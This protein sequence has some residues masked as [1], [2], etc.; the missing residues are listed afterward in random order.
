MISYASRSFLFATKHSVLPTFRKHSVLPTL[1]HRSFCTKSLNAEK[2]EAIAYGMRIRQIVESFLAPRT[3][4]YF[5]KSIRTSTVVDVHTEYA[6]SLRA[7]V[8]P[9]DPIEVRIESVVQE[10]MR[11]YFTESFRAFIQT[12]VKDCDRECGCGQGCNLVRVNKKIQCAIKFVATLI[13]FSSEGENKMCTCTGAS[14]P[15]CFWH[16]TVWPEFTNAFNDIVAHHGL[17]DKIF[18]SGTTNQHKES[19]ELFHPHIIYS[20]VT[21]DAVT[22]YATLEQ[23]VNDLFG[24]G[25][26]LGVEVPKISLVKISADS[27]SEFNLQNKIIIEGE[28]NNFQ[29]CL[30]SKPTNE[31][32][33]PIIY[34]M[35][36]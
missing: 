36:Y 27:I 13:K 1:C 26:E 8:E 6:A 14:T 31:N 23:S 30:E 22:L 21:D 32:V 12:H 3:P 9:S 18:L 17:S 15:H 24:L 35:K 28:P 2:Y 34:H 10:R 11:K 19:S 33:I 5:S 25:N 20:C 4:S 16:S 7:G 29:I